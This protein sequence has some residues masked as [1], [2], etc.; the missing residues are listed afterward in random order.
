MTVMFPL[1]DDLVEDNGPGYRGVEGVGIALHGYR[2]EEVAV[3]F[4]QRPHP[5]PF[6]PDDHGHGDRQV[7]MKEI[8]VRLR[9]GAYHPYIPLF[10]LPEGGRDV[11]DADHGDVKDR[12]G[13]TLCHGRGDAGCPVLGDDHPPDPAGCGGA[14]KG[15]QVSGVLDPIEDQE[16]GRVLAL[17]EDL[18]QIGIVKLINETHHPLMG[19]AR[20]EGVHLSAPHPSDRDPLGFGHADNP[21]QPREAPALRHPDLFDPAA[22]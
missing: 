5:S 13:R 6:P 15:P 14:D 21:L 10:D 3:P 4:D 7:L 2:D 11:G 18:I 8:H 1:P 19:C 17:L 22:A 9:S 12:P 16:K 20:G